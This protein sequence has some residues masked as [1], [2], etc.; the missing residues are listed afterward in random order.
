VRLPR[1]S[2]VLHLVQ[3]IRDEAHRFAITFHRKLRT[4]RTIGTALTDI[5]GVGPR[6]ARLLLRRFG[7]VRGVREAPVEALA[8]VVGPA[9]AEKVRRGL[10]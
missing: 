1:D 5:E 7:S 9:V 4:K 6:R 10:S 3:R 2:P 8:A